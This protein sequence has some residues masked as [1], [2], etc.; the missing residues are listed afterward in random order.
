LKWFESWSAIP[1]PKWGKLGVRF[2]THLR[3]G[4]KALSK[5]LIHMTRIS[6]PC[7]LTVS[8]KTV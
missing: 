8:Q 7:I 6:L 2:H 3:R 4:P 5:A 1:E